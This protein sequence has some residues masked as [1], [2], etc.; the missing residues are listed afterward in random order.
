MGRQIFKKL[1]TWQEEIQILDE[2]YNLIKA[3]PDS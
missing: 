2:S 3:F 1:K